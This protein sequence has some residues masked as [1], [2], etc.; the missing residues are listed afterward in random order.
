MRQSMPLRAIARAA[1]AMTR[2]LILAA[3]LAVLATP[4]GAQN[5]TTFRLKTYKI[6][7]TI[8]CAN[9]QRAC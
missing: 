6:A 1:D 3:A 8:M 7:V 9:K 4:A 2:I 5:Q